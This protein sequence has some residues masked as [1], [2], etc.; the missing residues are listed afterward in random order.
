MPS[1]L[2]PGA[3]P[4]DQRTGALRM[5]EPHRDRRMCG[6]EPA[7][8]R[9]HWIHGE[10]GERD[11]V[12][13]PGDDACHLVDPRPQHVERPQHFPRR[14]HERV[15]RRRERRAPP[16]AAEQLDSQL[17]FEGA[18]GV[19]ERRLR[20]EAGGRGRRERAVIGH[21]Q[22]VPKLMNFHR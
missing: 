12:E 3:H 16:D 1:S 17:A 20:D 14:G 22:G 19:G 21:R 18:D 13:V 9:G 6:T 10:G 15:A 5:C 4:V 8:H 11:E 2:V 7:D